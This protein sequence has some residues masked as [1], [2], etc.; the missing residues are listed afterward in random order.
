MNE[1]TLPFERKL[2]IRSDGRETMGLLRIGSPDPQVRNGKGFSVCYWSFAEI[3]PEIGKIYGLDP[4]DAFLNCVDFIRQLI[5]KHKTIGSTVWWQEEGD[6]GGLG[7]TQE[8][9]RKH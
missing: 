6:D 2:H 9:R 5:Q 4:L 3:H 1:L 7:L 8:G